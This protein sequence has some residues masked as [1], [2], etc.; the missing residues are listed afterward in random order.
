MPAES[1]VLALCIVFIGALVARLAKAL[2]TSGAIASCLVGG[3][4]GLSL[5]LAGLA[6]LGAF[7]IL[8]SAATRVG[9]KRKKAEGTA[10]RGDGARGAA[11]VLAKGGVAAIAALWPATCAAPAMAGALAA[12]LGDTLGTEFGILARGRP[13]LLPTFRPV[14]AG[15]PGAVSVQGTLAAVLGA[16]LVAAAGAATGLFGWSAVPIITGAGLVGALGESLLAGIAPTFARAPGTLRNVL[17]TAVGATIAGL[18]AAGG[19]IS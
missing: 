5:G 16:G 19:L 10:E 4:I 8:G 12:A 17:T 6:P 9:W 14:N 13:R 11:R 18:A 2:D 15:T 7:F 1:A 3:A